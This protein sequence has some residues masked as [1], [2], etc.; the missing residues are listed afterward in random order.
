MQKDRCLNYNHGR[1]NVQVRSCSMC[2]DV[3]NKNIPSK[4]CSEEEHAKSRRS[5]NKYCVDCGEQLIK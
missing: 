1:L 4:R 3:V 2:G 5:R